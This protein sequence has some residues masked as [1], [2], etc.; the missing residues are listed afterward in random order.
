MA[1]G[2]IIWRQ[3]IFRNKPLKYSRASAML[4]S[5]FLDLIT[6]CLYKVWYSNQWQI[7]KFILKIEIN[8]ENKDLK[9]FIN[10]LKKMSDQ[11]SITRAR[12]ATVRI[13]ACDKKINTWNSGQ[14]CGQLFSDWSDL[15]YLFEVFSLN[16]NDLNT[17]YINNLYLCNWDPPWF[18]IVYDFSNP[19]P[20]RRD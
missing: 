6:I 15:F 11:I 13:Q 19:E 1:H 14:Q 10:T 12:L 8:F 2:F 20:R 16:L 18:D 9:W 4:E 17:E 3:C 7:S 5:N